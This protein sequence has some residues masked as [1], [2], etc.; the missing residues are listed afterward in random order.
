MRQSVTYQE[1]YQNAKVNEGARQITYDQLVRIQHSGERYLL[2]DVLPESSY[3][4]GHIE[5]SASFPVDTITKETAQ[6]RLAK[7]SRIIV[8]CASFNCPASTIAARRFSE[9]GYTVL[10]YKGG[11]KDWQDKGNTL[12]R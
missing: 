9:L 2:L 8:Y 10:D 5:S 3:R 7:D 11:L 4:S 1:T 12:I 6:R